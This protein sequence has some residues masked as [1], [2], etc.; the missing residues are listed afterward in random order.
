MK[1]GDPLLHRPQQPFNLVRGQ[2]IRFVAGDIAPTVARDAL[3]VLDIVILHALATDVACVQ[4]APILPV[5]YYTNRYVYRDNVK[6]IPLNPR[7]MLN[8]KSVEVVK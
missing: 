2:E 6:G 7:E 1:G 8:F 4:E 3:H 5:Y